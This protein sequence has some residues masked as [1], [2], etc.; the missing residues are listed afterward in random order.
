MLCRLCVLKKSGKLHMVFDLH[1]QNDNM[2]K[3]V[4]V[5][6][7]ARVARAWG[8]GRVGSGLGFRQTWL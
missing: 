1:M 7:C 8:S 2:E 5:T 3:D 4:S 6:C